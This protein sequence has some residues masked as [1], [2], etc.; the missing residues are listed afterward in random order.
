[1][2]IKCPGASS[3]RTP[4]I[5][6]KKCP[7]CGEEVEIFSDEMQTKCDSCGVVIYND[8][9]SCVKWCE[10]AREC[11]GEERYNRLNKKESK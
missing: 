6:L 10:H 1:M 8:I 11:V 4:T 9:Q 3:I 2:S 5:E 7:K